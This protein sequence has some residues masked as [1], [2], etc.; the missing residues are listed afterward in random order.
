MKTLIISLVILISTNALHAQGTY[1]DEDNNNGETK[2]FQQDHVFL[3]GALS[4]GF[5]SGS[6]AVG[7]NPEIGYSLSQWF[8]AGL[9]FNLNYYSQTIYG[10]ANTSYKQ[11]SFNYGGGVFARAYPLPFLFLQIQPEHNWISY[12][13]SYG[14]QTD[15]QTYSSNSLIGAIGYGQR[16]VGQ[17][18]YFFLIGLDLLTDPNS[19]YL[20]YY[21]HPYP[22]IRGGFDIYLHPAK[23]PRPGGPSL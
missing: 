8:D 21:H 12:S 2:G 3:G 9:I 5:G 4:L 20:D 7:G 23:K 19:P 1:N 14:N 10:D 15:Q 11:S 22:I 18:S 13:S 17:G 16:V 6:F